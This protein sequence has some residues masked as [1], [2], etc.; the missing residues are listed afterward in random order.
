MGSRKEKSYFRT[1]AETE[2]RSHELLGWFAQVSTGLVLGH[3]WIFSPYKVGQLKWA[4][5]MG[6]YKF[7]GRKE[8]VKVAPIKSKVILYFCCLS[9]SLEKS[10]WLFFCE[11][12]SEWLIFCPFIFFPMV[13]VIKTSFVLVTFL[14]YVTNIDADN[15]P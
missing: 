10:E 6:H 9:T 15:Q 13:I 11:G 5:S 2:R 1:C 8:G 12:K 14:P 7:K 4:D 3:G